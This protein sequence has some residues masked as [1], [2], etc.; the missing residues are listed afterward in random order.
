MSI[1]VENPAL[2]RRDKMRRMV[3]T[4]ASIAV[5]LGG[6]LLFALVIAP[7]ISA[8]CGCG[9]GRRQPN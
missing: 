4:I 7:G 3:L 6:A 2:S 1:F 5:F 9:G 8:A